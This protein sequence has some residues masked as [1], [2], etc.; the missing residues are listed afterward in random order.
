MRL[1]GPTLRTSLGHTAFLEVFVSLL[2]IGFFQ[3]TS[4]ARTTY[5]EGGRGEG[6]VEG[7]RKGDVRC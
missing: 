5:G 3:V 4:E 2:G 6:R 7:E 1:F